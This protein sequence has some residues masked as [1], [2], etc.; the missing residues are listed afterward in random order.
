MDKLNELRHVYREAA[1]EAAA[2]RAKKAGEDAI[3]S[4]S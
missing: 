3:G 4:N 1:R 2:Q